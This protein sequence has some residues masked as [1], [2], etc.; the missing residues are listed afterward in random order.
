M[1]LNDL[2]KWYSFKK[3]AFFFLGLTIGKIIGVLTFGDSKSFGSNI[4]AIVGSFFGIMISGELDRQLTEETKT[5]LVEQNR[6]K[7]ESTSLKNRQFIRIKQCSQCKTEVP[8]FKSICSN[9]GS[10]KITYERIEEINEATSKMISNN[11]KKCPFCAEEIK[12]AAIKCKHCG[13]FIN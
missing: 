1:N 8:N 4:F 3:F 13:E 6:S 12:L 5:K 7:I 2:Y 11:S 9:C 10:N